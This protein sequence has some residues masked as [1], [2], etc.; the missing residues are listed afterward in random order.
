[1]NRFPRQTGIQKRQNPPRPTP[2]KDGKWRSFAKVPNLLQY[3]STGTYF[4]RVKVNG[5]IF[6]ESLETTVFTTAKL[7]MGDFVKEKT[8]RKHVDGTPV[9]FEDARKLYEQDLE[10]DDSISDIAKRYRRYCLK[11]LATSW[12]ELDQTKLAKISETACR[13][14]AA[15]LAKAIDDQYFNN[16]LGTVRA[17]F[18]RGGLSGDNDPPRKV[19][20]LGIKPKK[21]RS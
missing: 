18:K 4:A 8:T 2:S 15:R 20:R 16:V 6:R 14:W 7:K 10:A 21:Q 5:K 12:P 13:E 19:K 3:V 11:A 17:I 1:M 9:I